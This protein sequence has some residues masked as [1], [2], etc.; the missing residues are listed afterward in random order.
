VNGKE[1]EIGTPL[2]ALKLG[3]STIYQEFNLV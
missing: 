2:E 3:I 1:T